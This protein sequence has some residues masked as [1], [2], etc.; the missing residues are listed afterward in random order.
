VDLLEEP[1][2][3]DSLLGNIS[4]V[5]IFSFAGRKGDGRLA[6]RGPGDSG[7]V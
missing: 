2:K 4:L 1:L 6:F 5:D 3:P 7:G